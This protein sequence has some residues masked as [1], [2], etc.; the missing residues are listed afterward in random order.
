MRDPDCLVE[1][2]LLRF[3]DIGV[4]PCLLDIDP[5]LQEGISLDKIASSYCIDSLQTTPR[6]QCGE[7]NNSR[8]ILTQL[9]TGGTDAE[10]ELIDP[11]LAA[12]TI[13]TEHMEGV[14][15]PHLPEED[16][17]DETETP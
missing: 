6:R 11:L 15:E 14:T 13:S 1:R 7:N 8:E 10:T 9:T 3:D 17:S 2:S 5:A 12:N 16:I 4:T